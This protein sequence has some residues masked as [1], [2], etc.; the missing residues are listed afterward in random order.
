MY[1]HEKPWTRIHIEPHAPKST[2]YSAELCRTQEE[3]STM[4]AKL[5]DMQRETSCIHTRMAMI[6]SETNAQLAALADMSVQEQKRQSVRDLVLFGL[7]SVFVVDIIV[8]LFLESKETRL[9]HAASL[10]G[11]VSLWRFARLQ[12]RHRAFK[13]KSLVTM[14]FV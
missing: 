8:R 6:E 10:G 11:Y 7:V 2:E 14:T 5:E 1:W 12:Y 4:H 9:E 3:H 13:R